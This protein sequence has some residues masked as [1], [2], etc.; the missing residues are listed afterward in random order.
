MQTEIRNVCHEVKSRWT[1]FLLV[2]HT[3]TDTNT[4]REVYCCLYFLESQI[5]EI[6]LMSSHRESP[7]DHA[8]LL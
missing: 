6:P 3:N 5:L 2:K 7:A 4:L 1:D 8:P